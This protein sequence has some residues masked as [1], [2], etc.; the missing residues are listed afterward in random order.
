MRKITNNNYL[1][2][3]KKVKL[4]SDLV[5]AHY[6]SD[7]NFTSLYFGDKLN[8]DCFELLLLYDRKLLIR[9]PNQQYFFTLS[10]SFNNIRGDISK[11]TCTDVI[12]QIYSNHTSST[13]RYCVEML[14]SGENLML[15]FY[16]EIKS[17]D[18]IGLRQVPINLK[19]LEDICY[20][21]IPDFFR[22]EHAYK[23]PEK[24]GINNFF[25]SVFNTSHFIRKHF[26]GSFKSG[27]KECDA[28]SGLITRDGGTT[29]YTIVEETKLGHVKHDFFAET[30]LK[31]NPIATWDN[32]I[33]TKATDDEIKQFFQITGLPEYKQLDY[34]IE[35]KSEEYKKLQEYKKTKQ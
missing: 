27:F 32:Q 13:M 23:L 10:G 22:I 9:Y 7:V 33:I 21:D 16:D 15:N 34:L 24:N 3:L 11:A 20:L 29:E 2:E 4:E 8:P 1:T 5:T 19:E 35:V 26:Y 17:L 12:T 28:S 25:F 6:K 31:Q 18:F 30:P 14:R